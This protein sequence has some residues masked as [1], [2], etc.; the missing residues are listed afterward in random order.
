MFLMIIDRNRDGTGLLTRDPTR[1]DPVVERLH[2]AAS[3]IC[4][5]TQTV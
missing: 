2:I 4:Q 1:P 5:E 3:V